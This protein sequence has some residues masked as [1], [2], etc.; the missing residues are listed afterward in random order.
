MKLSNYVLVLIFALNIS[1]SQAQILHSAESYAY[2]VER[3]DSPFL[4]N[5]QNTDSKQDVFS[6]ESNLKSI[7]STP[8]RT[9]DSL[10]L[11]AIYHATDGENWNNPWDL[12]TPLTEWQGVR[13]DAFL[14]RVADL[15]LA[16][17][18][19]AGT[20]PI[21]IGNLTALGQLRLE[22]NHLR[23]S[24]PATIGNLTKLYQLSLSGNQLTGVIPNTIVALKNLKFFDLY[25]N[26]LTGTI[27][28]GIGQLIRLT[29]LNL[30]Q[31]QLSG[32]IPTTIGELVNLEHLDLSD[33]LLTGTIPNEIAHLSE[34]KSI[35]LSVNQLEGV[36]PEDIGNCKN[37]ESL[38]LIRNNFSGAIPNSI[39]QLTKLRS[40]GLTNNQFT[41]TIPDFFTATPDLQFLQLDD[42]QLTGNI[43]VS[44]ASLE[45]AIIISLADNH[46]SGTL[47]VELVDL[48][49]ISGYIDLRN[50]NISGCY[51]N[52][53][54]QL[55]SKLF[56]NGNPELPNNGNIND[57]CNSGAGS[58]CANLPDLIV[59]NIFTIDFT[60]QTWNF[61]VD[62]LNIGQ[63]RL[64]YYFLKIKYFQ[65]N[66]AELSAD[67]VKIGERSLIIGSLNSGNRIRFQEHIPFDPLQGTH[68]IAEINGDQ[69]H[70][71]CE[72]NNN[73][74]AATVDCSATR[75]IDSLAL[76]ELY[77]AT[78]GANWTNP[79]NLNAPMNTWE[80]LT[81]SD[82]N[83]LQRMNLSNRNLRGVLPDALGNLKNIES[84][85]ISQNPELTGIIPATLG[86]LTALKSLRISN[87]NLHGSIPNTLGQLSQLLALELNNN[88]L[89][90]EIPPRIT[91]I[92]QLTS[93]Y[94]SNNNL[95]GT[96]P[97]NIGQLSNLLVL[98]LAGNNLTGT[99]PNSING[100]TTLAHL[101]LANNELTAPLPSTLFE[102]PSVTVIN[103]ADNQF[104]Q[105]LPLEF[106][107]LTQLESL[108]LDG[109][110]FYGE[111]P[112]ELMNMEGLSNL[113]LQDN[114]LTGSIPANINELTRMAFLN[115]SENQLSGAIPPTLG[116]CTRLNR[117]ELDHNQL[118]GRI[119]I[120]LFRLENLRIIRLN[121]N[122]LSGCYPET[123]N[124]LCAL[125]TNPQAVVNFYNNPQLPWEGAYFRFCEG[126]PQ[127][128]APCNDGNELSIE[129]QITADCTCSG[130]IPNIE[131][132]FEPGCARGEGN[133]LT[134]TPLID[135]IPVDSATLDNYTIVWNDGNES[136]V[137]TNLATG[138]YFASV[139]NPNNETVVESI[140]VENPPPLVI[141]VSTMHANCA[142]HYNGSVTIDYYM[143][144]QMETYDD[145]LFTLYRNN[146]VVFNI[147]TNT[148]SFTLPRLQAG[149]YYIE[150]TD[151]IGCY[152][153]KDFTIAL[154]KD[155]FLTESNS[156]EPTCEQPN[157]GS[158]QVAATAIGDSLSNEWN[159]VWE[160]YA[161]D[162][163]LLTSID[164]SN[165]SQIDNLPLGSYRLTVAD[166]ATSD[167]SK[168][169]EFEL[170]GCFELRE[171]SNPLEIINDN[172]DTYNLGSVAAQARHWTTPANAMD[173]A[174]TSELDST[175][176]QYLKI[177]GET[178]DGAF[179]NLANY[180]TG[181]YSVAWTMYIPEN[182]TAEFELQQAANSDSL[183][184]YPIRFNADKTGTVQVGEQTIPFTYP[185]NRWFSVLHYIDLDNNLASLVIKNEFVH[186]WAFRESADR[187]LPFSGVRFNATT[188]DDFY[189]I[190]NVLV[191]RLPPVADGMYCQSA[192]P[193]N[194]GINEVNTNRCY[195]GILNPSSSLRG[196]HAVWYTYTPPTDG[197]LQVASCGS[198]SDT[199]LWLLKGAD[200]TDLQIIGAN[201]DECEQ[202]NLDGTIGQPYAS[203]REAMVT[204]GEQYYI[205]WDNRWNNDNFQFE[206]NF[207]TGEGEAGRFPQTAIPVTSGR[208]EVNTIDGFTTVGNQQLNSDFFSLTV[209]A[210]SKWY[211]YQPTQDEN[212]SISG[213]NNAHLYL[214]TGDINTIKGTE[215]I[216]VSQP[217]CTVDTI[218]N[219]SIRLEQVS[220]QANQTYYIEWISR[221]ANDAPFDWVFSVADTVGGDTLNFTPVQLTESSAPT[222]EVLT[223]SS[224]I[225]IAPNPTSGKITVS[226]QKKV[227][228]LSPWI[229][230][231]DING[232]MLRR[233]SVTENTPGQQFDLNLMGFPQ[234]MYL[235]RLPNREVSRIVLY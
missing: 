186:A 118:S 121:D 125:A 163:A 42:N 205:V 26:S 98:H 20:I 9:A 63:Q 21:E 154:E 120:E 200:C 115:L 185:T 112:S 72:Y 223:A 153:R 52:T 160:R 161:P 76:V 36:I 159:F 28:I 196:A 117:L 167:C 60:N 164:S 207:Q 218:E 215:I 169:F 128:G 108:S 176:N 228:I 78:D 47:P 25:D 68:L 110:Q 229:E 74:L 24:I 140:V 175:N 103:L 59:E 70:E 19:L 86:N 122:L 132:T 177:A 227:A 126:E 27:P 79:W 101:F 221:R 54:A 40:L 191:Y 139:T 45:N 100:L 216:A 138:T 181:H 208:Y 84:I 10:A 136:F 142:D 106:A 41:D 232:K 71:E 83:C 201:D 91:E 102:L 158:I 116:E 210:R 149:A 165:H 90:G 107:Q 198:T 127:I 87:C 2:T 58:C 147:Q 89:S 94:L 171:C 67:D 162:Y 23:D 17:Q 56:T 124:D 211:R 219:N 61:S 225:T 39:Q 5:D 95:T 82:N 114:E 166:S 16:E 178:N 13:V 183:L 179:L 209:Y 55:C 130:R 156:V 31:N 146:Q 92:S 217:D 202:T 6:S 184:T 38:A 75:Q 111:I 99:I 174:V 234:G 148:G 46:L 43:P 133:Q 69:S 187:N 170:G 35:R 141:E 213:C 188:D 53:Y 131:F 206:L 214:H 190:D 33:N 172:F 226:W 93:L 81:F 4:T 32:S 30:R 66:D 135:R 73:T 157:S 194:E 3:N 123:P 224:D 193:A 222:T 62:V 44:I 180:T 29:N 233:I 18:N 22:R 235:L 12:N 85:T 145:F 14:N 51:P 8:E 182:Q 189:Y 50:N 57:F 129:D 151:S 231:M 65:S 15:S 49:G 97:D 7:S 195:G 168:V 203:I 197:V 96:I 155:Y 192:Q 77:H 119:P 104:R 220:L 80:G 212:I 113:E 88:N 137:R 48:K 204:G 230:V 144:E 150:T 143:G 1:P 134:A 173:S 105:P 11:V 64:N 199:R 109:N 34:I 37:L 152:T